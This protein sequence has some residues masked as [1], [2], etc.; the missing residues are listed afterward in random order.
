MGHKICFYGE[1][2]LIIPKLALLPLPTWSIVCSCSSSC[3]MYQDKLAHLKK[4]LQQ[5]EDGT[6]PE[7]LKRKK[8]IE[9]QH[10]ERLKVADIFKEYEV[11]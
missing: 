1:I 2:W 4:Q 10:K 6:L 7:Y 3:R 11:L 8:K 9:Q 5:L